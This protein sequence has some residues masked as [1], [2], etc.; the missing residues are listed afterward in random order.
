MSITDDGNT[1]AFGAPLI[2][3]N[4]SIDEEGSIKVYSFQNGDWILNNQFFGEIIFEALGTDIAMSSDGA[5]IIAGGPF[6]DPNDNN[7]AVGGVRTYI[8][9][10]ILS[11]EDNTFT[12]EITAFPNPVQDILTINL[13]ENKA[14]VSMTI[15]DLL[16]RVVQTKSIENQ[17]T[18]TVN[19]N[20][21]PRGIYIG[22]IASEIGNT[23]TIRLVKQ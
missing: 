9:T 13:G 2:G 23:A 15:Y 11:L 1:I 12:T 10:N 18:F 6:Y 16:G 3:P 20:T 17:D 8:N 7:D 19:I 22:Q 14:T 21:L 4:N 5:V